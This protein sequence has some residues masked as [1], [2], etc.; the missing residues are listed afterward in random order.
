MPRHRVMSRKGHPRVIPPAPWQWLRILAHPVVHA[1][2]PLYERAA[3]LDADAAL[4]VQG[5]GRTSTA[6]GASAPTASGSLVG[7]HRHRADHALAH[8]HAVARPGARHGPD[9]PF[10]SADAQGHRDVPADRLRLPSGQG[11]LLRRQRRLEP[12]R[13]C[14]TVTSSGLSVVLRTVT[15]GRTGP[16]SLASGAMP[17]STMRSRVERMLARPVPNK[18]APPVATATRRKEVSESYEGHLERRLAVGVERHARLPQQE[19]VEELARPCRRP[20][21]P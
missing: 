20:P 5:I 21:P 3:K 6:P 1:R 18:T 10:D 2:H 9:L 4:A 12:L 8:R 11:E 14:R 7:S 13:A 16:L 15:S 19:R 17:G